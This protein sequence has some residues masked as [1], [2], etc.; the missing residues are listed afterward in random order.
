[1]DLKP[2]K[3]VPYGKSVQAIW[4]Y[5]NTVEPW[6]KWLEPEFTNRKVRG[7]NPTSASRLPLSGLG[8][9]DSIPAIVLPSGGTAARHRKGVTA[10]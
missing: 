6:C 7:S 1:M 9:P 2:A 3:R 5:C 10:E 4:P 8:Q